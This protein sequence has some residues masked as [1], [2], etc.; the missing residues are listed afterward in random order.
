MFKII[1]NK[2]DYQKFKNLS[3]E[4]ENKL[5]NTKMYVGTKQ[6]DYE[7]KHKLCKDVIDKIDNELKEVYSLTEEELS[8]IKLFAIKYRTG[9]EIND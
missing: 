9:G 1:S 3:I 7:Y 5:E 2:I 4:L 6:V 8:Y